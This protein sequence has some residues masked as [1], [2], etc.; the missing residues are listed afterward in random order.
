MADFWPASVEVAV[1]VAGALMAHPSAQRGQQG[2]Q[3]PPAPEQGQ[4]GGGR[5]R[6][7]GPA[8]GAQEPG[9]RAVKIRANVYM[10]VGAGA[11]VVV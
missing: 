9:V 6:G 10:L 1:L 11:N 5:G 2:G 4:R 8:Q 7:Q 3:N